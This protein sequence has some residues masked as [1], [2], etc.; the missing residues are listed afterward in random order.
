[1]YDTT[2]TFGHRYRR[3]S[4]PYLSHTPAVS[5]FC[6]KQDLYQNAIDK[7]AIFASV[8]NLDR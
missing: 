5:E 6:L 4:S 7:L 1:V 3:I 8:L 2:W